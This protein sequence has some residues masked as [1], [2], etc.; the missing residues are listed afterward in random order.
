MRVYIV[1]KVSFPNGW[2]ASNRIK[3]LAKAFMCG[4]AECKVLIFGRNFTS[5]ENSIAKGVYEEVPFEYIGGSTKRAKGNLLGRLQAFYLQIFLLVKLLISL[6]SGDY[7]CAYI[8]KNNYYRRFL[9]SVAHMKKAFFISELCELPFG[10]GVQNEVSKKGRNYELNKLF[11]RYDGVIAI[12]DALVNL[13][14]KYCSPRC[15][16]EKVPI[17]VDYEK[18]DLEDHSTE[19]EY[20]YIFHS[21]TLY[22]QK[23][24]ILGMIEAFG[25]ATKRLSTPLHFISTGQKENSPHCDDIERLIEEYQVQDRIHFVGYLSNE[26]LREALS[27]ASLVIINK[28]PTQQNVYCFSTKLGEYMAAGKPLII[29]RV[30]EAMNWIKE[31][32]DAVVV[33]PQNTEELT[34]A[35]VDL[36][37]NPLRRSD[38]GCNAKQT[39]QK[40]FDYSNYGVVLAGMLQKI[41]LKNYK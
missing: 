37:N 6:K 5:R 25:K 27:K 33:E 40:S 31:N 19:A 26:E 28:Y 12:S 13:A 10:T 4:G 15:V 11:P 23:D 1:T 30:G 41:S 14:K 38:I 24:G 35:I 21:G 9:L 18:Y 16:I 34:N 29:T 22:E 39:C 32:K 36:C 8:N 3:C 7:I 2:A 20:P 17:L